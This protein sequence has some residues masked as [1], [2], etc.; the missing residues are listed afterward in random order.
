MYGEQKKSASIRQARWSDRHAKAH[1]VI[2]Q[3]YKNDGT[4]KSVSVAHASPMATKFPCRLWH[5]SGDARNTLLKSHSNARLQRTARGRVHQA[6]RREPILLTGAIENA[7]VATN[8]VALLDAPP[9]DQRLGNHPVS[10]DFYRSIFGT[11]GW[12]TGIAFRPLKLFCG[13]TGVV[14]GTCERVSGKPRVSFMTH[15]YLSHSLPPD[16][17]PQST[18]S[19]SEQEAFRKANHVRNNPSHASHVWIV[20]ID[21]RPI[22]VIDPQRQAKPEFLDAMQRQFGKDRVGS[23]VR[24][25]PEGNRDE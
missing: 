12:S 4:S 17:T 22:R 6:C 16:S 25:W 8:L 18:T 24:L 2:S 19:A 7:N 21:G 11:C 3:I 15:S 5:P 23:C 20:Q 1:G 9:A 10:F 14:F 13:A